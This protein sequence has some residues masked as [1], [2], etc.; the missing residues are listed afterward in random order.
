MLLKHA[1]G[2]PLLRLFLAG[3]GDSQCRL[4]CNKSTISYRTCDTDLLNALCPG[5]Y[6]LC[7]LSTTCFV[8]FTE[9]FA[10]VFHLKNLQA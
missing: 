1:G 8:G 9:D 2:M 3:Q 4:T 10:H 7:Q 6:A 5:A